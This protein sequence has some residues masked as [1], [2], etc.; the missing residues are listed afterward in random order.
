MRLDSG[1]LLTKSREVRE[2]LDRNGLHKTLIFASGDLNEYKVAELVSAGAPIDAFGVGTELATSRDVPALSVVY[3]LVEIE[4]D[5][6]VEYKTE[7]SEKKAH[8]PGRKQVFR[9]MRSAR[10]VSTP[11]GIRQEYHHDLIARAQ[12]KYPEAIPLLVPVMSGGSRLQPAPSIHEAPANGRSA[13]LIFCRRAISCRS[14]VRV[15]PFPCRLRSRASSR[16]FGS[17]ICCRA[18]SPK[19]HP[20]PK[21]TNRSFFWM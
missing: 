3:K 13:V 20:C 17:D 10:E 12:E 9:F 16:K 6:Q 1:D 5:G 21:G 15:I 2:I 14:T 4:R 7:F 18:A 11:G 8:W 19:R